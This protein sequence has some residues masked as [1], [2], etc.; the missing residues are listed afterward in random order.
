MWRKFEDSEDGT[1]EGYDEM[2]EDSDG[3][4][5]HDKEGFIFL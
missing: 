2:D 1:S 4:V 3:D 5:D